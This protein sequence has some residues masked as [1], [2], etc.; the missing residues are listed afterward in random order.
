MHM[1][2]VFV[3]CSN[4]NCHVYYLSKLLSKSS[5]IKRKNCT[6]ANIFLC[7]ISSKSA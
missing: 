6:T 5:R 2:V 1:W 3:Q 7:F 4:K